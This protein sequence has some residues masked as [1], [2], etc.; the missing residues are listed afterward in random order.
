[1]I[2][3]LSELGPRE[4]RQALQYVEDLFYYWHCEHHGH[5][6]PR[7]TQ[8]EVIDAGLID[9]I[10][11]MYA[12]TEKGQAYVEEHRRQDPYYEGDLADFNQQV[13]PGYS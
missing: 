13:R 10:D 5:R 3:K 8:Q 6:D 4:R 1:M 2:M 7:R 9:A 11:G 12:M